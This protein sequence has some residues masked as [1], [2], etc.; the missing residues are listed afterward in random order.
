MMPQPPG[1]EPGTFLEL[2][3]DVAGAELLDLRGIRP[4][5]ILAEMTAPDAANTT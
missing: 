2:L 3:D 4:G 5:R 1:T